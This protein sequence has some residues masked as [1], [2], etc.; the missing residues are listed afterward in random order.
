MFQ[1]DLKFWERK[2][3]VFGEIEIFE[4]IWK[5]PILEI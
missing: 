4:Q 5:I 1:R 3:K 2:L